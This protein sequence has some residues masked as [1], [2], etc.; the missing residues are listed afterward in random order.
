MT[1]G[2]PPLWVMKA[3]HLPGDSVTAC[4]T[5]KDNNY[6]VTADTSGNMKMWDFTRFKFGVDHKLDKIKVKWF[7]TAHK[8]VIN[9]VD[10]VEEFVQDTYIVTAS[11]DFNIHL[12]QF[13]TGAFLG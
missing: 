6:L 5:T 7:I 10:I 3:D 13:S 4:A 11:N 2:Q 12:Y 1:P 8:Q 9:T